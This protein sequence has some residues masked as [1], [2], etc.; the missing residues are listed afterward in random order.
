[1]HCLLGRLT[2]RQAAFVS[3]GIVI[4]D[5]RSSYVTVEHTRGRILNPIQ[6][7]A[8]GGFG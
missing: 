7:S 1:M 8:A 2:G 4:T 6:A 5:G 3:I